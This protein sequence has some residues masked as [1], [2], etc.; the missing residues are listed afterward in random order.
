[1]WPKIHSNRD[2]RD[3]V[4]AELRKEFGTYFKIAGQ[5]LKELLEGHP[6]MTFYGMI[7]LLLISMT[8]SF[9]FFRNR[10]KPRAVRVKSF[11]PVADGFGQLM[12][13]TGKIRETIMLKQ[14]ID[15]L[16]AVKVLTAQDSI[17][18]IAALDRLQRL[19]KP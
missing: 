13:A 9:T 6:K 10:E 4:F 15:S 3:T 12:Q 8:L 7:A 11:A 14:Q 18:L 16:S 1:M 2:P 17:R 19:S 5:R